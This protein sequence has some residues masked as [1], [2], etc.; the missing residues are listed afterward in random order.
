M[1]EEL[2]PS[3]PRCFPAFCQEGKC[4]AVAA[5]GK[6]WV[7]PQRVWGASLEGHCLVWNWPLVCLQ[8]LLRF[9][10]Q[11]NSFQADACRSRGC[12]IPDP[13]LHVRNYFQNLFAD[14]S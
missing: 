12:Q 8:C 3:F 9:Q 1:L 7:L 11:S 14:P 13:A 5:Q 6:G 10:L 2:W 4:P